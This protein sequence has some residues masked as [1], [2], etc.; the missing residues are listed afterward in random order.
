MNVRGVF[1]HM[2][3]P[4]LMADSSVNVTMVMN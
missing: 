2:T 3:A 1:V 4:I